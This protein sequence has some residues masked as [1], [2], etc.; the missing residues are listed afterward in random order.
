VS[1][2]CVFMQMPFHTCTLT[3]GAGCADEDTGYSLDASEATCWSDVGRCAPDATPT[4]KT[5]QQQ[6][7]N[8]RKMLGDKASSG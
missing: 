5:T 6:L 2:R 3:V 7:D 1:V 4:A 8:N